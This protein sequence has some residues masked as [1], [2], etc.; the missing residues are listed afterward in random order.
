[1]SSAPAQLS[2]EEL[3]CQAQ[4]GSLVAFEQLVLRYQSK[5]LQF[6]RLKT[7]GFQDAEDLTQQTFVTAY[8]QIA[9]Y[10]S[11]YKFAAWIFTLAR[12]QAIAHYRARRH[13]EPPAADDLDQSD[14]A[15]RL[16]QAETDQALW[17]WVQGR[18]SE[19][20]FMTF[21][22]RVHEEFTIRE[23]AQSMKLTQIHVKVLLYRARQ[24][25]ARAW[26]PTG[27]L[28]DVKRAKTSGSSPDPSRPET[29]KLKNY[30]VLPLH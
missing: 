13:A 4:A 1:M 10:H 8:R 14:P 27:V 30:V 24:T 19:P 7:P 29:L 6:L 17:D 5:L 23:I 9:R 26:P 28:D 12:R 25:L 21:W 22:L 2:D 16:D 3:A 20:Q 18:L 11:R 15:V